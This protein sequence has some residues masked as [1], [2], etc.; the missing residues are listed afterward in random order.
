VPG[1]QQVTA[2][3][4]VLYRF[5]GDSKAGQ[6]NGEGI[7]SFGGTWHAV[8]ESGTGSSTGGHQPSSTGG[9][10]YGY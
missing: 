2:A 8:K 7:S 4:L 5:S 3:G 1:E 10:G 9:G 6:A